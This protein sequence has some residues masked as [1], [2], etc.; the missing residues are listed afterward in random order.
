MLRDARI[1]YER[2]PVNIGANP[3]YSHLVRRARG[4][5]FKWSS[6]M[7]G[8]RQISLTLFGSTLGTR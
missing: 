7:T 1:R 2:Q 3:N 8:P 4:E 6:S 5:F